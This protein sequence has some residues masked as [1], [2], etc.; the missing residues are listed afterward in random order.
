MRVDFE[1]GER[2]VQ[3]GMGSRRRN[4]F[5]KLDRNRSRGGIY[6]RRS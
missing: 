2:V 5:A 1:E 4:L 3:C 6:I